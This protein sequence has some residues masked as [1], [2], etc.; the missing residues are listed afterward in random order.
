MH[1]CLILP[2]ETE[3]IGINRD[4]SIT[5]TTSHWWVQ[6]IKISLHRYSIASGAATEF[7][8]IRITKDSHNQGLF[9]TCAQ[10]AEASSPQRCK[11][12]C[13]TYAHMEKT[14]SYC[15][16]VSQNLIPFHFLRYS[17]E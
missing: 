14:H 6:M 1:P 10:S 2:L 15:K 3:N 7:N 9:I 4:R 13:N 12:V 17:S 16:E 5:I 11:Y 8:H